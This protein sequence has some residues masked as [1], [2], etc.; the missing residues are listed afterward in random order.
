MIASRIPALAALGAAGAA[1]A[2]IGAVDPQKPGHYPVCPVLRYGGIYCPGCGG[3]RSVHA[4]VHGDVAGAV[5][6]NAVVVAGVV[7][8]V[9]AWAVWFVGAGVGAGAGAVRGFSVRMG[10]VWA[11]GAAVLVFTVVRNL[12]F[13]A[14]LTP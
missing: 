1:A 13:G 4:L 12:P 7:V 14:G 9:V 6:A 10:Y 5:G 8:L 3:L 11:A 2:Y